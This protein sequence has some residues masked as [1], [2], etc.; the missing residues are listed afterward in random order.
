MDDLASF[1][2]T[3]EPEILWAEKGVWR[4][5]NVALCSQILL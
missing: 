5:S 4:S 3:S 2:V 1:W